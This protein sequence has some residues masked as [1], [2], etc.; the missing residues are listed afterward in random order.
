[1]QVP[2]RLGRINSWGLPFRKSPNQMSGG[3]FPT[4]STAPWT[5]PARF[6]KGAGAGL[7]P[8]GLKPHAQ[9]FLHLG[10]GG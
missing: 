3:A 9:G 8:A 7:L 6:L 10:H 5:Q 2:G 1:M 4:L